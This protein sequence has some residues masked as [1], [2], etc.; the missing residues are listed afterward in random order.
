M[1]RT[2]TTTSLAMLLVSLLLLVP[3][4][5][6]TVLLTV[7]LTTENQLTIASTG[8]ASEATSSG[9]VGT[10][11]LLAG[12]FQDNS[13]MDDI[14]GRGDLQTIDGV[15]N[16]RPFLFRDPGN[17]GLNVYNFL[18][19]VMN[20]FEG[21]TA[22]TGSGTWDVPPSVY[23]MM[24]GSPLSGELYANADDDFD[25]PFATRIG[26]WQ[27]VVAPV[28]SPATLPLLLLG[29]LVLRSRAR[30]SALHS[31]ALGRTG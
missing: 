28:S 5:N 27:R 31:Q 21:Q 6:A 8:A 12:F 11:F 7:D 26:E 13:N 3:A 16:G 24:L 15:S 29:A 4:T 2:N 9:S 22:F 30:A 19:G 14:R 23:T 18:T 1:D 10:G 25:I 17:A 20:F